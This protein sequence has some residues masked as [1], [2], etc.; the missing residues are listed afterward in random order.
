MTDKAICFR[1]LSNPHHSYAVSITD[2]KDPAL[3]IRSLVLGT[4]IAGLGAAVSQIYQ[5]KPADV[6]VSSVFLLLLVL[7]LGK[8]WEVVFFVP[9]SWL[10]HEWGMKRWIA[11]GLLYLNPGPF[12]MKE[13][14]YTIY[15][16]T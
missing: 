5:F 1:S 4:I 16:N 9:Q 15:R 7:A 13:V 3:T 2:L 10:E 6:P 8:V 12:G 14:S 11:R